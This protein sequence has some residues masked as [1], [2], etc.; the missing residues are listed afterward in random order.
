M[1]VVVLLVGGLA[2]DAHGEIGHDRGA[3]ID[4]RMRGLRQ[5]RERAGENADHALGQRQP[6][7][8]ERSSQRD[9]FLLVL[10]WSW[11]AIRSRRAP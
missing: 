2:G 7:G 6:A 9:P 4:Q 1:A 5:D 3:E 10:H 8:R 11:I